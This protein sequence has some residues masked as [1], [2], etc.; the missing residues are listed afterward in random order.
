MASSD[1]FRRLLHRIVIQVR[2]EPSL[3]LRHAHPFTFTIIGH[4]ISFDLAEAEVPRFRVGE[5]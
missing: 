2:S 1:V 5:I 3:N 4:L